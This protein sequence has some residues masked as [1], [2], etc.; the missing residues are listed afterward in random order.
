MV[1]SLLILAIFYIIGV[2]IADSFKIGTVIPLILLT[3]ALVIH[4]LSTLR[5]TSLRLITGAFVFL[6][7]GMLLTALSASRLESGL[8][9]HAAQ[10]SS[11]VTVEGRLTNDPLYQNGVSR[12]D[13][14]VLR[15]SMGG[16]GGTDGQDWLISERLRVRV[17]TSDR[18]KV[19]MGEQVRISGRL[20]PPKSAGE[21]DYQRYL[22]HRGIT[23]ILSASGDDIERVN[24]PGFSLA[25]LAGSIRH[26]IKERNLASLPEKHA[27]LLNGIVLGDISSLDEGLEE[28]FRV[29]GLTHIVA[30]SG[31]NIALIV[32]ALWP[33]LRILRL[34]PKTQ[35]AVLLSFSGLYTMISGMQP[36]IT[37]AFIMAAVGLTAWIIGR[38]RD[39]LASISAAA[40]VLLVFDPFIL[41]DIGFQLSFAATAALIIALPILEGMM[42]DIPKSL[43][44]A[45][46]V[47]L[48]AQIGVLPIIVYYF[49]QISSISLLANLI[50]TPLASPALILGMAVLPFEALSHTLASPGYLI[51][52]VILGTAIIETES[53]SNVPGASFIIRQP[54]VATVVVYYIIIAGL[55][56]YLQRI[57]LRLRFSNIVLLLVV[58]LTLSIWAQVGKSI[59][60]SGLE[61]T[62]LDVGQGDSA[63]VSSPEGTRILID[64]GPSPTIIKQELERRGISKLDAIVLSHAHLD[65]AGG[66]EKLL[67]KLAVGSIVYPASAE[68]SGLFKQ[69]LRSA[70]GKGI[71]C[72]TIEDEDV[73]RLGKLLELD[74][75]Y[76]PDEVA[77]GEGDSAVVMVRYGNF[78]ALFTGDAGEDIESKLTGRGILDAD[79][80]KVGH[81]GSA[82]SS[83]DEFLR[84]VTPVISVIS[85][86]RDNMYGHPSR[87]A[88]GRLSKAGSKIYRT[89]TH[90]DVTIK[91]DGER[92][93]VYVEK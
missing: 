65:H 77:S 19:H 93:E 89:D 8:L 68:E 56:L 82:S 49:G 33:L 11:Y 34:G 4:L 50:V 9:Y 46:A 73:L 84:E 29:T 48:V 23:A 14:K 75:L 43:R 30:A 61:V 55:G 54:S 16:D 32:G 25:S 81:H 44:S 69:I 17:R 47:T 86:G 42:E 41:F 22:Y 10:Q 24:E 51:L 67:E 35:Y 83:T 12:F 39:N 60:P 40:L 64:S 92:F 20:G 1:P 45:L 70:K 31:I 66:V 57:K 58:V 2:V 91:S 3:L 18:L 7:L 5:K 36:S 72:I 52:R 53:L 15:L 88:I 79:I 74:T 28:S 78:K 6:F 85:V 62:F 37:R 76:A 21:F 26:W 71:K 59:A 80:L 13:M 38:E 27:G 90:G 87:S 63:L